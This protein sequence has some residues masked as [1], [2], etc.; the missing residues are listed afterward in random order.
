MIEKLIDGIQDWLAIIDYSD[1]EQCAWCRR[2][3]TKLRIAI[4]E[5]LKRRKQLS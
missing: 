2:N 4:R 5:K 1:K 3:I